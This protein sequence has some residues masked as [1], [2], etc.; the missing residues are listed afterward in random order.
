M[1][2]NEALN[3]IIK[4]MKTEDISLDEL[5]HALPSEYPKNVKNITVIKV[6]AL[7]GG[8]LIFSGIAVY[9]HM[10]WDDIAIP[11]R[12]LLTLG[13]GF[14][15]Y[16]A[17]I[18][19][20]RNQNL[21]NLSTPLFIISALLQPTGLFVFLHEYFKHYVTN[22]LTDTIIFVILFL[23]FLFTYIAYKQ[24]VLLFFT[25]IFSI[26]MFGSF[27]DWLDINQSLSVMIIGFGL[28]A[29]TFYTEKTN[30]N[31]TA[32]FWYFIG[33]VMFTGG[34][35]Y[36]VYDTAYHITII[37]ISCLV[38]YLSILTQSRV[39]LTIS[40][41]SVFS[42]IAYYTNKYFLDSVGWPLTLIALGIVLFG[43]SVIAFKINKK[44]IQS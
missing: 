19:V 20:L 44:Y 31:R 16:L 39:L 30:L 13:V 14:I 4:L 2:K 29:A 3:Q 12:V 27:F 35:S 21:F 25:F 42:Y 37:M 26:F 41:I 11:L 33:S 18:A 17:A 6:M 7:L 5:A 24:Q 34:L 36:Y 9:T 10:H 15:S 1:N 32:P 23:Q 40:L 8:L 38:L 43:L 28:L 22:E